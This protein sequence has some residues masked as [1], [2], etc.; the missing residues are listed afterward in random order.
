MEAHRLNLIASPIA[1]ALFAAG[2]AM[3]SNTGAAAKSTL[4]GIIA[5][6]IVT[7]LAVEVLVHRMTQAHMLLSSTWCVLAVVVS[8]NQHIMRT[9]CPQMGSLS[10]PIACVSLAFYQR[11]LRF[12][13]CPR[14]LTLAICGI[15]VSNAH[16]THMTT[17]ASLILGELLG[18]LL[19]HH[20][21][22]L[23][24]Q[25][26]VARPP[27]APVRLVHPL[28]LHFSN[29]ALENAFAAQ[30]FVEASP[31]VC[32]FGIISVVL[33][34]I[35]TFAGIFYNF[36][37]AACRC[38]VMVFLC[39]VRAW[40]QGDTNPVRAHRL[41]GWIWCATLTL[42]F[43]GLALWCAHRRPVF[44]SGLSEGAWACC[45]AMTFL[46]AFSQRLIA[47]PAI[48]RRITLTSIALAHASYSP[49]LSD[50]G[51]PL[52]ALLVVAALLVGELLSHPIELFHRTAFAREALAVD[53]VPDGALSAAVVRLV[54]PLT[55]CFS[56]DALENAFAVQFFA[57]SPVA[58]AFVSIFVT[59]SWLLVFAV[60]AALPIVAGTSMI[61]VALFGV[62]VWLERG[63]ALFGACP[64]RAHRRFGWIWCT[65]VTLFWTGIT[66][67]HWR[68]Q[69]VSGLST[70][71]WACVSCLHLL[72]AF[73]QRL[74]AIPVKPRLLT[75]TSIALAHAS[76]FPAHSVVGQPQAALLVAAAL[77]VGEA[78][79]CPLELHTRMLIAQ[80]NQHKLQL[81]GVQVAEA[82]LRCCFKAPY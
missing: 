41:F 59:L 21:V 16:S 55:L 70:G 25:G 36:P 48:P 53:G 13:A 22:R 17:A 69:L 34:G 14:L 27:A 42:F 74:I 46:F 35:F 18:Q 63:V 30:C 32:A 65:T 11:C 4:L 54:H 79:A 20:R 3:P 62:R 81:Q 51:Q 49:A 7:Q 15:S 43:I 52:E 26:A 72:M 56:D 57:A 82:R 44:V 50:F 31:V 29:D 45:L 68:W 71:A 66:L 24:R 10:V 6:C 76:F 64:V 12:P 28:T 5:V 38:I 19:D 61:I 9:D 80:T 78:L 77:L 47:I 75:L 33:I 2:A 67:A 60:P 39:G 73:F 58:R 23:I 1:A 40:L 8:F 37:I